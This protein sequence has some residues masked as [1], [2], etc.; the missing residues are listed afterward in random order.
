MSRIFLVPINLNQNELQNAVLQNL[1]ANPASPKQGQTYFNST[2]LTSLVWNGTSWISSDASKLSGVI[3]IAALTIDPT[4][5][6]NHSGSQLSSTISD[7][8][9][10]VVS[11]KLSAFA[12]PIA[13][14]AMGGFTFTGL[15]TGPSAAGQAAEYSW[16]VG[17]IQNAAAG[18]SSKDPVNVVSI[19]NLALSGLQTIDNITVLVGQRILLTAQTTASQNGVYTA[20]AGSWSRSV[21]EGS[22]N[23]ELDPGAQ[24]LVLSGTVYGGTQWRQSTTGPITPGTTSISIVL[25]G[26]GA[27]Y[28]AGNGISLI[29]SAFSVSVVASS[30]L[31]VSG[32][33]VTLDNTI[34]TKK[35]VGVITGDG[36]T[37]SFNTAHSLGG[38]LDVMVQVYEATSGST[39]EVDVA[40]TSTT[41]VQ[42]TFAVAPVSAK[43]Y[44]VVIQ[45]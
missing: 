19:A 39:V 16:V 38:G 18:I 36:S 13:N 24:W 45:G 22:V 17:Q 44:R 26:S 32:S 20:A 4:Q 30:G 7:F 28:T 35:S 25:T 31:L 11:N 15:N 23:G 29:G 14:I 1:A 3:P 6:S 34:V 27:S 12:A 33:G 8:Q 9:A 21:V 43:V 41:N 5:R 40:R 2:T 42:I 10:N 37:T